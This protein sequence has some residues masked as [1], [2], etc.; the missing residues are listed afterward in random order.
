MKA[1]LFT[2]PPPAGWETITAPRAGAAGQFDDLVVFGVDRPVGRMNHM[3]KPADEYG[4]PK[5]RGVER[6][7]NETDFQRV[8]KRTL[9]RL[10]N[11]RVQRA[12]VVPDAHL[13]PGRLDGPCHPDVQV[14]RRDAITKF[15]HLSQRPFWSDAMVAFANEQLEGEALKI[16]LQL[17]SW[18]AGRQ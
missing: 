18:V 2:R 8:L 17:R 6:P 14:T 9:N 7:V 13:T 15:L 4:Q 10:V 11:E 16:R 1:F 5:E 3:N 12:F